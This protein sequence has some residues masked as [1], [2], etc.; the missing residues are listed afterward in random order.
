MCPGSPIGTQ[1]ALGVLGQPQGLIPCSEPAGSC[2]ALSATAVGG[3]RRGGSLQV[4]FSD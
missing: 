2:A 4:C 1:E 3:G